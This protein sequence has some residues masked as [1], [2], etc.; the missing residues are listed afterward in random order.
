MQSYFECPLAQEEDSELRGPLHVSRYWE[1]LKAK[2]ALLA[3]FI[4]G[5]AL[6]DAWSQTVF[7]AS[8]FAQ[9]TSSDQMLKYFVALIP[10]MVLLLLSG[11]IR[12]LVRRRYREVLYLFGIAASAGTGLLLFVMS[13]ALDTAWT[14]VVLSMLVIAR[15]CL[16]VCW[17]ERL[18]VFPLKDMWVAI[19]CAIALGA[20]F[21]LASVLAPEAVGNCLVVAAPLIS[22]VLLPVRETRD[23]AATAAA[24]P[25]LDGGV[26]SLKTMLRATPWMLVL[27]LGLM[28]IPSETLVYLEMMGDLGAPAPASPLPSAITRMLVNLTAVV[29][30]YLAVRVNIGLTFFITV[31]VVIIVS[32]LIALG[33]DVPFSFMHTVCRIGS[34]M[35][36]YVIVYLLFTSVIRRGVPALFCFSF[37]TLAHYTGA[38]FG[39]T[40]AFALGHDTTMIAMLFMGVLLAAMLLVI[41]DMQ[42]HGPL[43][44][45]RASHVPCAA[46]PDNAGCSQ[47]FAVASVPAG[48]SGEDGV[49]DSGDAAVAALRE[50]AADAPAGEGLAATIL[51][52]RA[53]LAFAE[54]YGLTQREREVL[55]LWVR[56]RT[57]AYIEEQ[58]CISKYT[59]KT[60]VNHIYEKTGVNSKEGLISL[61]EDFTAAL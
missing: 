53:E 4:V 30:A 59:V 44:V 19:G 13:G 28:N 7:S 52:P 57:A 31:P 26:P 37:M 54:R 33:V 34:E 49:S 60:H 27:V 23:D 17:W 16:I 15:V 25:A 56:G 22:V 1:T 36:R 43:V 61:V 55:A 51:P 18:T 41:A 39:V 29:L 20:A 10:A 45:G 12:L 38:A 21:N 50:S 58:L 40:T 24:A 11:R 9:T 6:I 3:P 5:Y 2:L 42:Y 46:C 32:F 48:S 47:S 35:V 8:F 14:K